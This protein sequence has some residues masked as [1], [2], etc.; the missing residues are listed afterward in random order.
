MVS[1]FWAMVAV[2]RPSFMAS[3]ASG[4]ASKP[5]TTRG[6]LTPAASNAFMTPKTIISLWANTAWGSYWNWDP[7]EVWA[8]ITLLIYAMILHSRL[9]VGWRG[10]RAAVLSIVGFTTV[11]IA[12]F[13]VKLLQ[14]GLHVFQ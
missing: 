11:L 2:R 10:K 6:V 8:L 5:T 14:K 13:G 3:N 7:R 4:V 9:V 12:F 1:G